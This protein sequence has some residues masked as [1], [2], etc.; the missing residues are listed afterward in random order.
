MNFEPTPEQRQ[1]MASL[2]DA[3]LNMYDRGFGSDGIRFVLESEF[4][5]ICNEM[6]GGTSDRHWH[7]KTD[8]YYYTGARGRI[9]AAEAAIVPA[10]DGCQEFKKDDSKK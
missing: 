5:G 8:P 1:A 9:R 3:L 7:R 2:K 4:D 10:T 6:A